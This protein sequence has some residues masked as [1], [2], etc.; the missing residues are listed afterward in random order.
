[1]CADKRH[2]SWC[3]TLNNP[4]PE[5]ERNI[6]LA[7]SQVRYMIFGHE[8]GEQGTPHL[9]GYLH[10]KSAKTLQQ[11]KRYISERCH[12]EVTRGSPKDNHRYCSKGTNIFEHG[13]LPSQGK[14]NDLK[15]LLEAVRDDNPGER[16]LIENYTTV[17]A[18]YPRFV[19]KVRDIYHPPTPIEGDLDNIWMYGPPGTGKTTAAAERYPDSYDKNPD[20]WFDNYQGQETVIIDEWGPQHAGLVQ[21]LKRWTHHRP[22]RAEIKGSSR[23]IRPRRFVITSNYALEE[24]FMQQQDLE[25]L[26]R[27]FKTEYFGVD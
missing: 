10:L 6:K 27:R 1:M 22:F 25:A 19:D 16:E 15:G 18:R 12:L 11:L 8:I 14:R 2:R 9:Q 21:H 23:M 17:M 24:C 13:K 7:V 5:E 3:F 20:R 4:T 26:R